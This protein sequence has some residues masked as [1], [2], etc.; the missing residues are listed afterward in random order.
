M[1]TSQKPSRSFTRPSWSESGTYS[2]TP[3]PEKKSWVLSANTST[4]SSPASDFKTAAQTAT[5]WD[6][7]EKLFTINEDVTVFTPR[8]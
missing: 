1:S 7:D 6:P 8:P 2:W 3:L 4:T 5:C